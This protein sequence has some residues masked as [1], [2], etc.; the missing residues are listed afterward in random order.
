MNTLERDP[1]FPAVPLL[2]APRSVAVNRPPQVSALRQDRSLLPSE[3][4]DDEDVRHWSPQSQVYASADVLAQYLRLGWQVNAEVI[5]RSYGCVSRQR[6]EVYHFSLTNGSERVV[7][8][9]VANPV[10]VK[11]VQELGL[12]T[13]RVSMSYDVTDLSLADNP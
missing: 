12:A 6:V 1:L 7:M 9:V 11:L 13:V 10:V 3:T 2:M 8:P 4:L 5:V